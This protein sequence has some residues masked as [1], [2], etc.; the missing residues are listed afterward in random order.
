MSSLIIQSGTLEDIADAIRAKTGGQSAMT[1]AEMI[2]AIGTISGGSTSNITFTGND[3]SYFLSS[4]YTALLRNAG[5]QASSN[6]ASIM[7]TIF[8]HLNITTSDINNLCFSGYSG[9]TI[10]FTI[11]LLANSAYNTRYLFNN[12]RFLTTLPTIN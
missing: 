4:Y 11:N 7:T 1:P 3:L 2:T 10:P 6:L 9:A 8:S 5:E 12:C